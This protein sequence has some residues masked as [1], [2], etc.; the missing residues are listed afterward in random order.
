ML[1]LNASLEGLPKTEV[2]VLIIAVFNGG[3]HFSDSSLHAF[4]NL[5]LVGNALPIHLVLFVALKL[6][7]LI[8][9]KLL[10]LQ[11]FSMELLRVLERH[12]DVMRVVV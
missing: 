7:R 9:F 5:V 10:S 6:K 12:R 3:A 4:E 1:T 8:S 11:D 2:K